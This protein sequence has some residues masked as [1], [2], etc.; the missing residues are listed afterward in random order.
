MAS[1]NENLKAFKVE[2][3]AMAPEDR[4]KTLGEMHS[5]LETPEVEKRQP[6]KPR[7]LRSF[8]GAK[9]T[10]SGELEYRMWRLHAKPIV[11]D[12]FLRES[13]K[14]RTLFDALLGEA[15]EIASTLSGTSSSETLLSLLDK[16]FGDVSDGFELY[17][18]FRSAVQEHSESAP[19]FLKRLHSLALQVVEKKGMKATEVNSQVL[20]QFDSNCAD[21]DL[22]Q[23]LNLRE[24]FDDPDDVSDLLLK[25]R[26]EEA[27]RKE[28]KLKL[29]ARTATA[30]A[31]RAAEA[32]ATTTSS[33]QLD[34]LQKKIES[35]TQQLQASNIALASSSQPPPAPKPAGS[36]N[37]NSRGK[38]RQQHRRPRLGFCFKCGIDGHRQD[39]CSAAPNPTLVQQRLLAACATD[40]QGNGRK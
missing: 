19:D 9:V 17:S 31:I 7:K 29:K 26:T 21:D 14:K 24:K 40:V 28:K 6:V 5:F 34:S 32:S 13:E 27:R 2:L 16:H 11:D 1:E 30:N 18:Q 4:R 23:R 20:R 25:V 3:D 15:L 36:S 8:S 10:P 33:D 12:P 35:L 22:L 38:G 37:T 39:S